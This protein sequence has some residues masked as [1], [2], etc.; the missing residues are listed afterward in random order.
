VQAVIIDEASMLDVRLADA[1]V[2]AVPETA[3]LILIG[4]IDQLP[5]VGPGNVLRDLIDSSRVPCTRLTRIFRQASFSRIIRTAHAL[6][7]G[8]PPDFGDGDPKSDCQFF[9]VETGDDLKR[10]VQDL[11]ERRIPREFGFHPVTDVQIL[12]PMNRGDL[13]TVTLNEELQGRLNPLRAGV[14]EYKRGQL[15]FRPGDK[16]IQSANNYDLGVFNGDIG[17]VKDTRVEGGRLLIAFGDDRL[18]TY[19]DEHALD[20]RLAY[21]ITIHKSQGSEFPVVIIPCTMQHYVML[22]RNLMYTALTRARKLAFFVGS[23]KALQYAAG[24]QSSGRRQSG[25]I[26]K[27]KRAAEGA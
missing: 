18:V 1:L 11:V 4:D 8:A 10:T 26:D 15:V 9:E 14:H 25:L 7:N 20:L 17:F 12:T 23:K 22:Q 2:R 16:V 24:N 3:Q 6:N 27:L 13:G 21:A 5:S 19:E